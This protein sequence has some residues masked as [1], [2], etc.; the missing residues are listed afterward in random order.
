[1]HLPRSP[2]FHGVSRYAGFLLIFAARLALG[3]PPATVNFTLDFPHSEPEH[4]AI[5]VNSDCHATYDSNGKLSLQSDEGV[6]FHLAFMVSSSA[7]SKIF[8]L[9][10]KAHYFEGQIDSNRP[11]LASTGAKTLA[12]KDGQ[13][14]HQAAYNYSPV[15]AVQELTQLFQ[16][17]STTLEFGRR[18]DYY[19]HYQKLALN[20]E[21]KALEQASR[22]NQISELQAISPILQQIVNDPGVLR[23]DRARAQSLLAAAGA[24][25]PGH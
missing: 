18:L 3:V 22:D 11:N 7:C 20:D 15:P 4:Y 24:S 25:G 14:S 19:R 12:Y 2:R 6:P 16:G 5:A 21:L 10:K 23:V 17:L 9:A 8:S 13:T 1:M